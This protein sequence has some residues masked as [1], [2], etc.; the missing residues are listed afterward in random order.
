MSVY[1]HNLSPVAF[2]V[3]SF[4]VRWYGL[5]YV[6]GMFYVWWGMRRRLPLIYKHATPRLIDDLASYLVVGM[7]L[8]G[9]LGYV[10]LY[11]IQMLWTP[12]RI[13]E[14]WNG[15]MAFHGAVLGIALAALYACQRMK[16]SA[17]VVADVLALYAPIGIFL[18]RI[19]NFINSEHAGHPTHANWGV[20]FPTIDGVIRHPSQLYEAVLEGLLIYFLVWIVSVYYENPYRYRG[21]VFGFFLLF[22]AVFRS[23]CEIFRVPDGYFL[24]LTFGQFLSLPLVIAGIFLVVARPKNSAAR[25]Q[26]I[27]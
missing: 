22:Y 12:L 4:D 8:G 24:G 17:R 7:L 18:G 15:G 11:D 13:L 19:A 27:S 14:V 21:K 20:V 3:G 5:S 16:L 6:L 9:R 25:D 1:I 2:S 26:V 10:F 23:I